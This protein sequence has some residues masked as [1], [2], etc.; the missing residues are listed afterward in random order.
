MKKIRIINCKLRFT[1]CGLRLLPARAGLKPPTV[2]MKS[3]ILLL[4][5]LF[6]SPSCSS[7]L[8]IV[9]DNTTT[10]ED[11]FERREMALQALAK[12]YS[13][14][15]QD[16]VAYYSTW[17]LGDEWMGRVDLEDQNGAL[18]GMRIMRGLQNS[19][20]PLLGHWTGSVGGKPLYQAIRSANLFID[21]IDTVEDMTEAEKADFKAQAKFLKAYFHFLLLQQYGPIVI[22]DES[23]PLDALSEDL[24]HK[25]SKLEDC[26]DFIIAL[27]NEAIPDLKE[28]VNLNDLGQ[29]DR[30]TAAAIKARVM[31]FRAS[32]FYNGNSEYYGDF[33]D[34]DG[35]PFFPM[36]YDPEKWKAA[37]DAADEAIAL[38][39]NNGVDM[40][41]YEKAN[42]VYDR[43]SYENNGEKMKTYYDLRMLITDPWNRELIWGRTYNYMYG[44][45]DESGTI[46]DVSNI[47]LSP[48]QGGNN[49]RSFAG[50][51]LGASY[52]AMERYYTQNG[53]PIEEDLTFDRNTMYRLAPLPGVNDDTY[54]PFNGL[55]QPSVQTVRMYL[56]R[57]MRFYAN[58]GITGG[59]WR[60]HTQRIPVMMNAGNEGGFAA[61]VSVTNYLCT[62]IG[63][64]KFVHPESKAGSWQ[65]VIRYPYPIIRLADLYLM[66]AEALNEYLSAPNSE[67]YE[68]VD[69]VRLR[70]GLRGVRE[71]WS[72]PGIVRAKYLNKHLEQDGMRE[73]ILRER[74]IELAFEGSRFWDM[75][76]HKRAVSE[77]S[78]PITGW[79]YDEY[80]LSEFFILTSYQTRRFIV[81][82][83]LWPISL[84]ETNKNANLIQNPGWQ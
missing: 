42:F 38:C 22:A 69:K 72:N 61:S 14:L 80:V 36:K 79:D 83:C 21:N 40:Y 82:D 56:N 6:C 31:L 76:R 23:V 41:E 63:V 30:V 37:A 44:Y 3:K 47:R 5:L 11:F 20:D 4:L 74:S 78:A 81:R 54:P 18:P 29:V 35:Q 73:I 65:R 19:N 15:P 26:F 58:L 33:F 16:H 45:S 75:Y 2:S 12:V 25:R 64:Q 62:G 68:A 84:S 8:D 7:Y 67:V 60:A 51:W 53:L 34:F 17:L 48:S 66:K 39:L 55:M 10:I 59:Y 43:D 13:Y 49:D 32:P 71:T 57:E 27:M 77:F 1:N 24:F 52:R 28:R 9:P 70:A 50:Q 46:S